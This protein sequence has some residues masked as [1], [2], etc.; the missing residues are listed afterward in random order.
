MY[1]C[2][3]VHRY[4]CVCMCACLGPL[5]M[6]PCVTVD[7]E[8][9][10]RRNGMFMNVCVCMY[11]WK[12]IHMHTFLCVDICMNARMYMHECIHAWFLSTCQQLE[13]MYVCT[14]MHAYIYCITCTCVYMYRDFLDTGR[15]PSVYVCMYIYMYVCTYH[16]YICTY[17]YTFLA[18]SQ[19]VSKQAHAYLYTCMHACVHVK[20]S[21]Q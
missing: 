9:T 2:A 12:Y 1:T 14:Y 20:T 5:R 17:M 10:V 6:M 3:C 11:K 15:Q 16:V 19:K 21:V 8:V 18:I 13:C 7:P 4:M